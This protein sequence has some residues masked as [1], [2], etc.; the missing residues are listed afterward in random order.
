M[1]IHGLQINLI[2]TPHVEKIQH[3]LQSQAAIDHQT[4]FVAALDD[5]YEKRHDV[6]EAEETNKGKET[7]PDGGKEERE[8]NQR[9]EVA[10]M[11]KE[12][13]HEASEESAKKESPPE[14]LSGKRVNISV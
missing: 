6:P 2:N 13:L 9:E 4:A 10:E 3:S 7:D 12:E 8:E 5:Q 11:K 1:H 14:L